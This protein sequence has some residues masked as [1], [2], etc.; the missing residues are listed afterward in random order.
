[1]KLFKKI[2]YFPDKYYCDRDNK[3]NYIIHHYSP[4]T[5]NIG[6]HFVI[7][8]I[9]NHIK[10]ALPEALFVPK[11]IAQNRGWGEPIGLKKENILF[12]NTHADAVIV[13]GSDQYNNWSPRISRK[14]IDFLK[15][16]LFL[17]GLGV[18]SKDLN[19]E[20][21]IK[22]KEF[23]DD[24]VATNNKAALSSVRDNITNNFLK[25]IGYD[26]AI[27]TGCPALYLFDNEFKI[28]DSKNV[29]LTFS[30]P[31]VSSDSTSL[32]YKTTVEVAKKLLKF[33]HQKDLRPIIVCQ[34][35]RDITVAQY[36][37][38]DEEIFFSNYHQDYY[39]L[40]QSALLVVGSRLHATIPTSGMGIPNINISLDLRG[41]GFAQNFEFSDWHLEYAD[42]NLYD[43][44]IERVE[45]I[46][47]GDI[48]MFNKFS[49]K[50]K[51][52]QKIFNKFIDDTVKI[53]KNTK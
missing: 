10:K 36:E 5:Y 9:R 41:Q 12:S 15:P 33:L 46:L 34:D 42:K 48:S 7:Q 32:R 38:S 45:R 18:S 19:M 2:N 17:I 30:F 25:G 47:S 39:D 6:D 40:Y 50:R 11:A 35:D 3:K 16:P 23:N 22:N 14:E 1:M 4:H 53:I 28:N 26:K 43:K 49:I 20:P 52:R 27:N 8:S 37:F 31:M 21:Y 44:L 51:E 24:I 13:G 29:L